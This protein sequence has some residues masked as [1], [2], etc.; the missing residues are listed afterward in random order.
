MKFNLLQTGTKYL[1]LIKSFDL[2]FSEAPF[3][4]QG[5]F[6]IGADESLKDYRDQYSHMQPSGIDKF[7]FING[8][9]EIIPAVK[10]IENILHVKDCIRCFT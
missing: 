1:V 4:I 10:F 8:K 5:V 6:R 2:L 9:T 7:H 3:K